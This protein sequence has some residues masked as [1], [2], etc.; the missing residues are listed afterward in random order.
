[1]QNNEFVGTLDK[2][3]LRNSDVETVDITNNR[4]TGH[5][6][7]GLFA[8]RNLQTLALSVNC[9]TGSLPN[10]ICDM[11]RAHIIALDGLGAS[12]YCTDIIRFPITNVKLFNTLEGTL[13]KN[14]CSFGEGKKVKSIM[15]SVMAVISLSQVALMWTRLAPT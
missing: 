7:T 15:G 9:F 12:P 11:K 2:D 3:F 13:L 14:G 10:E 8:A 6:P 1:M 4:L 5:L